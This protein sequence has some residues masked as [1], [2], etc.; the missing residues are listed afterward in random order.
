MPIVSRESVGGAA[1]DRMIRDHTIAPLTL[2]TA[3]PL[4]IPASPHDRA[5]AIASAVP[6]HTVLSSL[7][8][9][10]V[11][12]GGARP[13][14]LDLVGRRGLHRAAPGTR[15]PGW[16]IEFHAGRAID[17]ECISLGEVRVAS[18]ERCAAD[19][20]RWRDLGAALGRVVALV[21]TGAVNPHT[22]EELVFAEDSRGFGAA[23]QRSAWAATTASAFPQ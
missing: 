12:L 9:I 15:L 20:L 1:F 2:R 16:E 7:A 4:D 19:A 21:R 8:G 17:E 6:G 5:A 14:V 22:V 18:V 10:W 23:R 13:G 11:L 3:T